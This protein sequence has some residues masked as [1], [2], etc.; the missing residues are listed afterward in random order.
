MASFVHGS[1]VSQPG[2]LVD[3]LLRAM[4]ACKSESPVTGYTRR[5]FRCSQE[6]ES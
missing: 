3:A 4:R 6:Y 2:V 5:Q 1:R